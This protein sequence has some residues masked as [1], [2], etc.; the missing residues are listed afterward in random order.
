MYEIEPPNLLNPPTS[1]IEPPQ[2]INPP[3]Y[4]M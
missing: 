2:F 1:E 4:E 3:M